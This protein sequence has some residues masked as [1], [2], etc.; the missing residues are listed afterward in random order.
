MLRVQIIAQQAMSSVPGQ[1]AAIGHALAEHVHTLGAPSAIELLSKDRDEN[2]RI[3]AIKT[4]VAGVEGR[5]S[6]LTI[7]GRA[8]LDPCRRIR[9][10]ALRGLQKGLR[11]ELQQ[12]ERTASEAYMAGNRG[13]LADPAKLKALPTPGPTQSARGLDPLFPIRA[14]SKA[15]C[16]NGASRRADTEQTS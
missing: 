7:L 13:L 5:D 9:R 8:S 12:D 2:V 10:L 6:Y 1:R 11:S 3:A 4:A 14:R 16:K 15:I